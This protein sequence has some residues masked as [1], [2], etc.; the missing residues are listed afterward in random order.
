MSIK[1]VFVLIQSNQATTKGGSDQI[2]APLCRLRRRALFVLH[3]DLHCIRLP[4]MRSV[5]IGIAYAA[6]S[7]LEGLFAP[8][9]CGYSGFLAAG[10]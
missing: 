10:E 6:I 8:G 1:S 5:T 2:E 7:G 9:I 3:P 4:S